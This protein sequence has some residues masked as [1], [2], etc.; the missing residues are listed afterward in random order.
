MIMPSLKCYLVGGAVRDQL[1]G[2]EIKDR[3]WV[4]VGSTPNELK[5]QGFKQVGRDFPVFLH[6]VSGE[7]YALARMERKNGHGYGGF[8]CDFSPEI[9]LEQ[10]LARRDLTINA[11]ALDPQG[12]LQDP[13]HGR[14]DLEQR[15][16]RHVSPAF[17]ED[18]L[19]VL[20]V[21]RFAARFATLGFHIAE[22][23]LELMQKI[24]QSGELTYLTPERVWLETEKA[25]KGE[26]PQIYF[27][28]LNQ[29]GALSV[30]F[31]PLFALFEKTNPQQPLEKNIGTHSLLVLEQAAKLTS[32]LDPQQRSMICF[33]AL[34]HHFGKGIGEKNNFSHHY[35]DEMLG[36]KAIKQLCQQLKVAKAYQQFALLAA[37][38]YR[39]FQ[40]AFELKAQTVVELFDQLDLWRKPQRLFQLS[41]VAMAE[42]QSR[43]ESEVKDYPNVEY[44]SKLFDIA[45]TVK[46]QDIIAAGFQQHAIR[47]ELFRRRVQLVKQYMDHLTPSI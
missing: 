44:L 19:R 31:P 23:T 6:P 32:G 8:Y 42:F 40:C 16:L 33:A 26:N 20:R 3:D 12:Q 22:E 2:L 36:I 37:E 34:C 29:I 17:A 10:D 47:E 14:R 13:Y 7:E 45:Q 28:V 1:L 41:L 5:Q 35:T 25:L 18:P 46:V 11:M 27:Q 4:V 15:L 30:L 21:A 9:T 43:S 38:F 24:V 39:Y